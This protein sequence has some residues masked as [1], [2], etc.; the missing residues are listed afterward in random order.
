M[1]SLALAAR[2]ALSIM[3]AA[4]AQPTVAQETVTTQKNLL[5]RIQVEDFLASYFVQFEAADGATMASFYAPD[6][7]FDMAGRIVKGHEAIAKVYRVGEPPVPRKGQFRMLMSNPHIVV[8]GD[9][10]Q[11]RLMWT[12]IMSDDPYK[13]P[14]LTEQGFEIDTLVRRGGRWYFLK[15]KL[16]AD[17]GLVPVN[18]APANAA[19]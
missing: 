17:G 7:E 16:I 11:V 19:P 3:I 14:R 6:A 8:T 1:G 12:G 4:A 2:A 13:L 10:A 18:P 9:T 15:R 5:A